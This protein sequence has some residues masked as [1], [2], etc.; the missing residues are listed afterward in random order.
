MLNESLAVKIINIS[1]FQECLLCEVI[2]S[3]YSMPFFFNIKNYSPEIINIPSNNFDIK[4]KDMEHLFYYIPPIP[5]KI[6]EDKDK[7]N[8]AN[9]DQNTSL[10]S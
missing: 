3:K 10:F 1:F 6:S 5:N 4:Q 8:T 9:I 7:Q 2:L